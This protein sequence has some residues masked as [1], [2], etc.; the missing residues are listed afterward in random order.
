MYRA[1]INFPARASSLCVQT[2]YS[3][4]SIHSVYSK[5]RTQCTGYT[6]YRVKCRPEGRR[7]EE[8]KVS[9]G[10][11]Y[12]LHGLLHTYNTHT[13]Y[14]KHTQPLIS[15][16]NEFITP[17]NLLNNVMYLKAH[18]A[19]EFVLE[20]TVPSCHCLYSTG[21][22]NLADERREERERGWERGGERG[23]KKR[24]RGGREEGER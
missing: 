20:W 3:V 12:M 4:Y 14:N 18:G 24:E 7:G 17:K 8:D 23:R 19:C 15:H 9:H 16:L 11:V 13:L 6:V 1:N 22:V 21:R 10:L 2:A 5:Q